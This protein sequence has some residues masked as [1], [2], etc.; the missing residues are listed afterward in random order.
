MINLVDLRTLVNLCD[1]K[2]IIIVLDAIALEKKAIISEWLSEHKELFNAPVKAEKKEEDKVLTSDEE[3]ELRDI[4][5][6]LLQTKGKSGPIG[7]GFNLE[8]VISD[9]IALGYQRSDILQAV[10]HLMDS[11][12]LY[13]PGVGKIACVNY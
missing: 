4:I 10:D 5:L 1:K 8:D 13:E 12:H 9:T 11:G 2:E 6:E 3:K 7:V